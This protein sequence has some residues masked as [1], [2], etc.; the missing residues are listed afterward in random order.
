M[1]SSV[2]ESRRLSLVAESQHGAFTVHQAEAAGLSCDQ[3]RH[4]IRTGALDRVGVHV[5]RS[6]FAERTPLND[7]AALVLDS[8]PA[9]LVAGPTA[10]ALHGCD[11][12]ALSAPFHIA[13]PRGRY[14][15]RPPHYIHTADRATLGVADRTMVHGISVMAVP[16]MLI[17]L[18]RFVGR[19]RL[20]TALDSML[21]DR[22]TTEDRLHQRI[23][24]L[25]S[26][27]R[28]GIP[29]LIDVLEGREIT[30]GG[31]SWLERRFLALC[32]DAM[33]PRPRTQQEVTGVKGRVVRVDFEFPTGLVVE[34]LGYRWHRGSAAQLARDVERLNA[35][36][37][38]GRLPLQFTYDH[39]TCQPM[40]VAEQVLAALA[41]GLS[42]TA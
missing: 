37:L 39:V 6:P 20:A 10:A 32:H 9:S 18:S 26:S 15:R 25:R 5:V 4:R 17:D 12:F 30:R 27:G 21:R 33:L 29:A 8:G 3:V 23:V 38:V 14:V 16:R 31:H 1:S 11:G 36:A 34:V 7:L 13:V 24:A 2:P 40:W 42:T 41:A 22:R 19:P 28:H 35:L